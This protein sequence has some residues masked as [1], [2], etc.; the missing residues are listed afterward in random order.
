MKLLSTDRKLTASWSLVRPSIEL[1]KRNLEPVIYLSF[2]PALILTVGLVLIGN[3]KHFSFTTRTD[4]GLIVTALAGLWALLSYPGY[5]H[6]QLRATAGKTTTLRQAYSY[7]LPLVL[8]L[9]GLSIVIAVITI[10]GFILLIIPGLICLRRYYLATY[11]LVDQKLSIRQAMSR[12]AADT[13]PVSGY[14]WGVLGV[15]LVFGIIGSVLGL[16]PVAGRLLNLL[17]AYI[18]VFGPALRYREITKT[19]PVAQLVQ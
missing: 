18:Y 4:I 10:I 17:L 7:G 6:M 8:R 5:L 3:S 13:K 9:I 2:L 19:G 15:A 16:V 1:L 11:Y 14:I 12:S